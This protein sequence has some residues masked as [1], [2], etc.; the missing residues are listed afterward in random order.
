MANYLLDAHVFL[1]AKTE[2]HEIRK[3]ALAEIENKEN[4]LFVSLAALW[5]LAIKA[6]SGKLPAFAQMIANGPGPLAQALV[7]SDFEILPIALEHAL[8]A[9]QLPPHHGDPFDRV[10]IAQAIMEN[11][12]IITRDGYF[13]RYGG[14][15]ILPA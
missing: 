9:A 6:T 13:S 8:A 10:M 2:P 12:T 4:T 1:W 14:V 7:E 11:L 5:E 15:H 3:T